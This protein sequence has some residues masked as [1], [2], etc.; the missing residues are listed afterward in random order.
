MNEK[1][2]RKELKK[3]FKSMDYVSDKYLYKTKTSKKETELGFDIYQQLGLLWEFL[4]LQCR[5]RDGYKKK[6]DK[7]LCKICGKVKGIKEEYYLLPVNGGK[8]I[9]RMVKPGKNNLRKLSKKEAEI[10][11][12]TIKFHGA[13]LN[14]AVF[15][16]YVSKFGKLDK[17]INIA[18]DRVVTLEENGLVIDISEYITGIKTKRFKENGQIYGGFLWELPKKI[19]RKMPII[20]SYDKSGKLAEIELIHLQR[21]I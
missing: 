14:I 7:F 16:E 20:L 3:L 1:E 4:S 11:N 9:G 12:D 19:L 21:K 10:V 17:E 5:H 8:V 2:L 15:K 6:G 13:K 18:A